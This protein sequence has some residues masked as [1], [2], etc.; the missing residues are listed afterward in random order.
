[1]KTKLLRT[2]L[3]LAGILTCFSCEKYS[4]DDESFESK[5]AN[6]TLIIRTRAAADNETDGTDASSEISY[7]INVYVFKDDKCVKTSTINSEDEELSLKMAEGNYDVYAIAGADEASYE[8]P[9]QESATKG[10]VLSLKSGCEHGDIMTAYANITLA[11]GENNTL[12][13]QLERKVMMLESVTIKNVPDNVTAVSVC[14]SPLH[15]ALL[16]NGEYSGEKGVYKTTL[17]KESDGTTW[18]NTQPTYLLS[19]IGKATIKILFTI[20]DD[21]YSYSYSCE[22]DLTANHKITIEGTYTSDGFDL[23]GTITGVT[24]GNPINITFNFDDESSE[25]GTE[26]DEGSEDNNETN[27]DNVPQPGEIYKDCYVLKNE[28]NARGGKDVTLM[29]LKYHNEWSFE[30]GNQESMR[31]EINDK[32]NNNLRVDGISGW[33]LATLKEI[34]YISENA[35]FISEAISTLDKTDTSDKIDPFIYKGNSFLCENEDGTIIGYNLVNGL[36]SESPSVGPST[37]LR[38]FT[39]I[40]IPQ[41]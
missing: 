34:K 30:R 21:D 39:T 7:P 36:T 5:E 25:T 28:P 40:T 1:M 22:D 15:E 14:I 41:Q 26:P 8:L 33:R 12:T 3:L 13:L 24:W 19:A 9:A 32:I 29:S 27:D 2:F 11:Y 20:G 18:K 4:E 6:S 38:A 16:L 35:D 10:T 23:K 17:T 31:T 37:I